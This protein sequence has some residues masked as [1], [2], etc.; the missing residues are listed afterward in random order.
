MGMT[1]KIAISFAVVIAIGALVAY[2]A[3]RLVKA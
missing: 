1:A 2:E 3:P